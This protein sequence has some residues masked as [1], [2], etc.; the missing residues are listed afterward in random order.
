M[1]SL[2][3]L[4]IPCIFPRHFVTLLI[5][6]LFLAFFKTDFFESKTHSYLFRFI[7]NQ[8]NSKFRFASQL[9]SPHYQ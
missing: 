3:A 4:K 8:F 7:F 6:P 9:S 2:F 5:G 1:V